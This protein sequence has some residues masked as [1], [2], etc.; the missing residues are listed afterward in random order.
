M[1]PMSDKQKKSINI[2][3]S[4]YRHIRNINSN[5]IFKGPIYR[6]RQKRTFQFKRTNPLGISK[7]TRHNQIFNFYNKKKMFLPL[8]FTI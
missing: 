3:F 1:K 5:I 2:R 4:N 6:G 7:V 8:N